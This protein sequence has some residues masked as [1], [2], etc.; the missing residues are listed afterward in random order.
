[1]IWFHGNIHANEWDGRNCLI[2]Q[3]IFLSGMA[4]GGMGTFHWENISCFGR[5]LLTPPSS[6]QFAVEVVPDQIRSEKGGR[7]TMDT[8]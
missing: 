3:G 4:T 5:F 6:R 7:A 8:P 2:K 1:L